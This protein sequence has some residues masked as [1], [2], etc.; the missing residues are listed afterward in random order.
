VTPRAQ[1]GALLFLAYASSGCTWTRFD[2]VL[3]NPPVERFDAPTGTSGLGTALAVFPT[4]VGSR[5]V[6]SA[7]DRV[8]AYDL[9]A[10]T[11]PS[12]T[13]AS[14]EKC[15]GDNSCVLAR[16]LAAVKSESLTDNLGC[17]AY[18][19]GLIKDTTTWQVWLYC[20]GSARRSRD[21]PQKAIDWLSTPNRFVTAQTV[22]EVATPHRIDTPA[23]AAALPDA[24]AIWFYDGSN[25]SPVELPSLPNEQTAGRA[26]A[27]I[28]YTSGHIVA[29]SSVT[30]DDTVWLFQV[31]PN[32]APSIV[33]C[34][35]G[36]PQF[37][38]LL[39][40]GNFDSDG[41]DD[42]LVADSTAVYAIAGKGLT[43]LQPNST[44]SCTPIGSAQVIARSSCANL[45]D[46][47]G[48]VGSGFASSIAAAN[49]DG[50]AP[51]ELVVGVQDTAVRGESA[52]GAVFLYRVGHNGFDVADGLFVSSATSGDRLGTSVATAP[53]SAVDTVLAGSPGDDS[54]MEFFC[55]SLMPAASR[56]ARCP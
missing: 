14:T 56:S 48:C 11:D 26:L 49:L 44:P 55:N 34:L 28:P 13:A 41:I 15:V 30:S 46:L 52:A 12:T 3:D 43:E 5:L 45:T 25:A 47:N 35:N 19:F 37:G 16:H 29:A 50:S 38:R 1:I 23:L 2:D 7:A 21:L 42:L 20:D 17:A 22:F 33:G 6:A 27:V 18:G 53:V 36:S 24:A 39:A 31:L 9:G 4:A 8:V 10:G 54:V 40:T 32:A 51:D